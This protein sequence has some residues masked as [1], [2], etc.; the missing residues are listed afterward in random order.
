METETLMKTQREKTLEVESLGKRSEVTDV[1]ITNRI[2]ER[3]ER[4]SGVKDTIEDIG[5]T[6]EG[7]TKCKKLL[8][9]NIQEIQDTKKTKPKNNKYRRD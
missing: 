1:I 4:I 9:E 5:K 6:V 7:N 3:K 2:Q 8:K